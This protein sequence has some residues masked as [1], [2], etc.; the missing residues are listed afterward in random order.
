MNVDKGT[1]DSLQEVVDTVVVKVNDQLSKLINAP[2]LEDRK[3]YVIEKMQNS[4][5]KND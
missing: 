3:Q 1:K 5:T 4:Q 2:L